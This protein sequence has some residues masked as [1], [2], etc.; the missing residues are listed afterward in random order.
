MHFNIWLHFQAARRLNRA[1]ATPAIFEFL[2]LAN[3]LF[4][5]KKQFYTYKSFAG[6]VGA[7]MDRALK[8]QPGTMLSLSSVTHMQFKIKKVRFLVVCSQICKDCNLGRTGG[9]CF[10]TMITFR[11]LSCSS[12]KEKRHSWVFWFSQCC[13]N[14]TCSSHYKDSVYWHFIPLTV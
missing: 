8:G 2:F 13:Q 12:S 7:S 4:H 11:F 14:K 9:H 3:L 1:L 6:E 10:C 5:R